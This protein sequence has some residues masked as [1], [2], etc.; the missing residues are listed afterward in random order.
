MKWIK[1]LC[2]AIMLVS[3]LTA[4][5][6][7]DYPGNLAVPAFYPSEARCQRPDPLG[8]FGPSPFVCADWRRAQ[9]AKSAGQP[10]PVG[11]TITQAPVSL[12]PALQQ[13]LAPPYCVGFAADACGRIKAVVE[14]TARPSYCVPGFGRTD[15]DIH[16][17]DEELRICYAMPDPIPEKELREI[18]SA[19][20]RAASIR[21][22]QTIDSKAMILES[23]V[24]YTDA[25]A[26]VEMGFKCNVI[27]QIS[28]EFSM[29][30][31]QT[32]MRRIQQ[33]AG[34]FISDKEL[35]IRRLTAEAIQRG[36]TDAENGACGRMTP[37]MRGRLR[38]IV[39]GLIIG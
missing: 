3:I 11:S 5:V 35:D 18:E 15:S 10:H 28:A 12:A 38:S 22:Q 13:P 1:G 20:A 27:D 16:L 37:A 21:N 34:L 9:E 23:W 29:V 2:S 24:I 30:Q 17:N 7:F 33:E 6:A 25:I 39:S 31:I 19:Q 4:C 8:L 32:A 36:K 14:A 26:T